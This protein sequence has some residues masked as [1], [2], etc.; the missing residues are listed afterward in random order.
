MPRD[1]GIQL[2]KY[3]DRKIG[4]S[5]RTVAVLFADDC[6]VLYLRDDLQESYSPSQYKQIAGSFRVDIN[7]EIHRTDKSPLEAKEALIHYH[8]EAYVFQFP[9]E[10]CHSIL[11]S[12][13]SSVGPQLATFIEGCKNQV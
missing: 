9:H 13:E 7:A 11:L 10:D 4:D 3:A 1:T 12:V 6:E 2:V 8:R 5:L